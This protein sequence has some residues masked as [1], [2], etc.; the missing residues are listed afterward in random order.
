MILLMISACTIKQE[1]VIRDYAQSP[2]RV[3]YK[4]PA[5]VAINKKPEMVLVGSSVNCIKTHKG[6]TVNETVAYRLEPF[7]SFKNRHIKE[8]KYLLDNSDKIIGISERQLSLND[9]VMMSTYSFPV[10]NDLM[11]RVYSVRTEFWSASGGEKFLST[12]NTFVP[13]QI[14]NKKPDRR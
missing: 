13:K 11:K 7:E 8:R 5:P 12:Q 6:C 3:E 10:P 1:V 4:Q 9:E 14:M 2:R